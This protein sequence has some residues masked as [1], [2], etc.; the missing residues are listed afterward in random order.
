MEIKFKISGKPMGK[1]RPQVCRLN[2]KS[3]AYTPLK[4]IDYEKKVRASY[5]AVSK[6]KFEKYTPIEVNITAFF[7]TPRSV[8]KKL[9]NAMLEGRFLPTKKPDC[10]NII[11]I[12]LDALNGVAYHD[13]SQVCKIKF[14]KRYA[15]VPEVEVTIK[16]I[17]YENSEDL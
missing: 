5:N 1:Q 14:E 11:K 7:S 17:R 16:E 15:Q 13:D 6:T 3:V 12:I 9:T 8:S 10:D 2:G 4:T